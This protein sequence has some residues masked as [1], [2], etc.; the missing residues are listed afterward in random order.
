MTSWSNRRAARA[1]SSG[2]ALQRIN[3]EGID[4][5]IEAPTTDMLQLES[6][7]ARLAAE[8]PDGHEIV[9]LR[10][11]AGLTMEEVAA[12]VGV[13]LSTVDEALALPAILAGRPPRGRPWRVNAG[14]SWKT[15]SRRPWP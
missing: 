10:Y 5:P 7:L 2:G 12:T 9:M 13:S 14:N 6:A 4:P 1:V 15:C 3:L 11:F 8:D